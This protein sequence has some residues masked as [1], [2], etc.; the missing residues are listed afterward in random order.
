MAQEFLEMPDKD[1]FFGEFGGQMIPLEL[2]AVMDDIAQ[3]YEEVRNSKEFQDELSDL[4]TITSVG[5]AL[6]SMQKD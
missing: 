5:Q 3:A 2:K 6:S 4:Y 1:G